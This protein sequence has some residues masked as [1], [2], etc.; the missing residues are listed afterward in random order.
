MPLCRGER[1]QRVQWFGAQTQLHW[2][3]K[4]QDVTWSGKDLVASDL[5]VLRVQ[6]PCAITE[7]GV[8]SS[9]EPTEK[10]SH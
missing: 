5:L 6:T 10:K 9:E 3:L 4:G 8:Q 7:D 2:E 1:A